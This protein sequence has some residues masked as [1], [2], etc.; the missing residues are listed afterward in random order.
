VGLIITPSG[1]NG[2]S[3]AARPVLAAHHSGEAAA[4]RLQ[5]IGTNHPVSETSAKVAWLASVGP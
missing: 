4:A 5:A 1:E 2:K 3:K